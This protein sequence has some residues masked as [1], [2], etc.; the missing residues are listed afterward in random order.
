M[1]Y[2]LQRGGPFGW[3][4]PPLLQPWER[5]VLGLVIAQPGITTRQVG[6]RYYPSG[7]RTARDLVALHELRILA[8]K[9]LVQ[10]HRG[11][12]SPGLLAAEML[13]RACAAQTRLRRTRPDMNAHA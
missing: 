13:R 3:H 8:R 11:C 1:T 7:N 10:Y 12:W 6:D 2:Q 9:N 4:P 5:C